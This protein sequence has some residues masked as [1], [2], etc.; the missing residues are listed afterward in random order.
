MNVMHE[1]IE[2][3]KREIY[4]QLEGVSTGIGAAKTGWFRMRVG[5]EEEEELRLATTEGRNVALR[6]EEGEVRHQPLIEAVDI[7]TREGI[8]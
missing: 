4:T 6:R 8:L 1:I 7:V 2:K 3:I 5:G